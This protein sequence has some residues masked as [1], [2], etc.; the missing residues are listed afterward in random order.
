MKHSTVSWTRTMSNACAR[1]C[2]SKCPDRAKCHVAGA[3]SRRSAE[4]VSV[5]QAS[6]HTHAHACTRHMTWCGGACGC[7]QV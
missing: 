6:M 3:A 1:T 4:G 5:K 7:G 2:L